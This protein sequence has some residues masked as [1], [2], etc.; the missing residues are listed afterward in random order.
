M[1]NVQCSWNCSWSQSAIFVPMCLFA[2]VQLNTGG[3]ARLRCPDPQCDTFLSPTM[4]QCVLDEQQFE[5]YNSEHIYIHTLVE[6]ILGE[7]CMS[8]S[9]C[10]ALECVCTHTCAHV[11]ACGCVCACIHSVADHDHF[12]PLS[13]TLLT[14]IITSVLVT[15]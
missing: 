13:Q 3:V 15:G 4:L 12:I 9:S 7:V 1:G 10:H 14:V 2:Q 6:L 11:C 5:R 8:S